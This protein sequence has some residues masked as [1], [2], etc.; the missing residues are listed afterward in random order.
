MTVPTYEN[1]KYRDVDGNIVD[2]KD[3]KGKYLDQH[4]GH[5]LCDSRPASMWDNWKGMFVCAA[6]AKEFNTRKTLM[7][8]PDAAPRC[9]EPPKV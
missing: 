7:F 1:G 5:P 4:C 8:G 3:V 6:C 2:V 9:I